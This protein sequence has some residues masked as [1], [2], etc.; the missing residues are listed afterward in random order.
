MEIFPIGKKVAEDIKALEAMESPEWS[1]TAICCGLF[2]DF[3]LEV[4]FF[5]IDALTKTAT[6]WDDGEQ[7]FSVT[8]RPTI[9][10]AVTK[11]LA[12]PKETANRRVYISSFQ[13]SLNEILDGYKTITSSEGWNITKVTSEE[14][15]A[16]ATE[17]VKKGENVMYSIGRLGLATAVKPGLQA[18]FAAEGILDNQMLG[19]ETNESSHEIIAKVL[20]A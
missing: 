18:D 8:A 14:M 6:I 5:G 20:K 10:L 3:C 11:V 7:K 15:V 9:G 12:H 16:N 2:F 13:C 17:N 1:W 4:G 19:L